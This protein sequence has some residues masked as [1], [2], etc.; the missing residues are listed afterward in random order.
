MK[1]LL[2][3]DI[4]YSLKQYDW[5]LSAAEDF[6]AV[7]IAGD[8]LEIAS[9]V[10]VEAQV[11]VVRAYLEELAKRTRLLVCSGNHDLTD[12]DGGGERVA[13]W[14]AEL[15]EIDV[16]SDGESRRVGGVLF[17]VLP[18]W[19][20]PETR[21]RIAAQLARDA[22]PRT[23]PWIWLHHA[24]PEGS[25]TAWGGTRAYGDAA[26]AG[27]IAQHRPT[28]VLSGHVHHA[29][30]VEAGSWA[31]RIGDT[32]VF[33]MGQQLGPAPAHIILNIA[34]DEALWFSLEG[35]Q[36]LAMGAGHAAAPRPLDDL[37]GWLRA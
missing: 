28:A 1:I 14:V 9:A 22:E 21:A 33:N 35:R 36:S 4:H 8:L 30:F 11:V 32:W 19:D 25:A 5:I 27:W 3:A 18:W 26:L 23:E 31:D 7:C 15:S 12:E 29:P 24:P 13:P 37:P 17:S 20:G 10:P 16:V 2:V 34:E 6:D